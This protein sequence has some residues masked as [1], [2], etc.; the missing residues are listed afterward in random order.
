MSETGAVTYSQLGEDILI[1]S[2]LSALQIE[3][4][5]YLDIGAFHPTILSN[6]AL[7][8]MRG[9]RGVCVEPDP[10]L[11]ALIAGARPRDKVI[12]AGVSAGK[13]T[14]AEFFVM[15]QRTLNT[16]SRGDAEALDRAGTYRI[17]KVISVPLIAP[18]DIIEANFERHPNI[19][20]LDTEG[21]DLN[22][23][24]GVNFERFRPEIVCVEML[25][26]S[27]DRREQR[28]VP[29]IADLLV[30]NG[31]FAYANTHINTIF[32]DNAAWAR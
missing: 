30:A 20:S 3:H 6:T 26:F 28:K 7:F 22:I 21:N 18:N 27:E 17:E 1:D 31:Y 25:T 8:Y 11:C 5:T 19:L 15:S 29:E 16:L 24:R 12:N 23:L 9:E 14:S 2:V 4:P 13:E 32:V 10:E